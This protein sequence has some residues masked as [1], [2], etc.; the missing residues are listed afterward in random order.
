MRIVDIRGHAVAISRYADPA[1][2]SGELTTSIVALGTDVMRGGGPVV[3]YGF[4]SIGRFGQS[5]LINERFAP[6]LLGASDL[7]DRHGT[8]IDPRRGWAGMMAGEKPGGSHGQGRSPS[9]RSCLRSGTPDCP[10]R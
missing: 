4:S 6:R 7:A 1:L 8:N 9:T 3:G 2:P 5:G 10:R